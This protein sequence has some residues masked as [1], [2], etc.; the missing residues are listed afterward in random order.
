MSKK[1]LSQAVGAGLAAIAIAGFAPLAALARSA[2]SPVETSQ[3]APQTSLAIVPNAG[4]SNIELA[5]MPEVEDSAMLLE[6]TIVFSQTDQ[7]AMRVY[8]TNGTPQF[9]LYNK[10]TG[11]TELRGVSIT[12]ESTQTGTTYRYAGEM[13]VEIAIASSGEQTITVNGTPLEASRSVSGTVFY[14]PRIALPPNAVVE[15]SLVDVSRADAAAITLASAKMVSGGRQVPFP[16]ELLYDARQIGQIDSQYTY[17]V[18]SRIT[19]DGELQFVS[20]TQFP[21]ITNGNPTENVQVQVD[22]VG[23]EPVTSEDPSLT[24]AVWQLEQIRYNNDTQ[25]AIDSLSDYTVEFMEDGQLSIRADCNQ[26]LGSFTEDGSSLSIELGPTT[27]AA[28]PP[29]SV[30]TE[31]LQG[32][33][34][35]GGYF[36][37]DGKLFVDLQVDTGTMQFSRKE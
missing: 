9:N 12:V 26:A 28:C 35:A 13:A 5:Q 4:A 24:G 23:Q 32:L 20:T 22:P 30:A 14:R 27:L 17:A 7:L 6:G 15:V 29:E 37:Q 18:Q 36:F 19:V 34:G 3:K 33:Q 2:G 10:Q 1:V 31:Y 16:F 25:V 11:V 8:N 21:V